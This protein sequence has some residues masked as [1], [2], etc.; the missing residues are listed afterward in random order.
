MGHTSFQLNRRSFLRAGL[1][2]AGAMALGPAFFERAFAAGPVTVGAGPYGPLQPFDSN[3]IAL[4]AG[5]TSREIARG[6]R[7]GAGRRPSLHLAPGTDGQAT[8]PTLTERPARRRLDP[9]GQL[10]V[11]VPA[12][13]GVSGVEFAA[14]G[15]VERAY[16]VLAGTTS[17]CAGGPTPWG[18]WLSCEEHDQGHRP[19]VR[20]D[21]DSTPGVARPGPGGL[22]PRGGLRRSR[23]ASAST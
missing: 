2:T 23:S 8:F 12:A 11:P 3:G 19:R 16:R 9:G 15:T 13:G 5:F 22:R 10:E 20:P 18:T 7:P 4:P 17:N 1:S 6:A 14:D 21:H